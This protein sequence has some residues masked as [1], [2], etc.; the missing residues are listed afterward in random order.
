[1]NLQTDDEK[2]KKE[3]EDSASNYTA[4]MDDDVSLSSLGLFYCACV[5]KTRERKS[6]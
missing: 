1:M 2:R 5:S 6:T 3:S 4:N